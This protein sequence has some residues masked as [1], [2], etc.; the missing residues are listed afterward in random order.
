VV[1]TGI[2][3]D[4]VLDALQHAGATRVVIVPDTHQ[5]TVLELLDERR[6]VPVIRCAAEDDVFGVCAGL[7]LAGHRPVAVIQQL[8]LFAGVNA[9]RGMIHD[10]RIPLAIVA[11][12]YGRDVNRALADDPASAVRL[13]TPLL[14]ALEIAWSLIESPQDAPRIGIELADAFDAERPRVVLLGAPTV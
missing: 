5:R 14:D 4:A 6:L 2:S 12:L 3:A 1:A 10:Q 8:G 11:G 13:C 7:W 9:L